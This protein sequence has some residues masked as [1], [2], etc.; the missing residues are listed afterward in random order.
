M[1]L[2]GL[3]HYIHPWMGES[4]GL[5]KKSSGPETDTET[6]SWF[7]L[8]IP[9]PGFGGTLEGRGQKLVKI[10]KAWLA[11]YFELP[12]PQLRNPKFLCTCNRFFDGR[13]SQVQPQ[14]YQIFILS[15][16]KSVKNG[17]F[18]SKFALNC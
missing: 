12:H 2:P 18:G 15:S 4:L 7:R 5:G 9:K 11:T 1:D 17:F 14:L 13:N 16:I 3:E 6:W 8:L 10:T